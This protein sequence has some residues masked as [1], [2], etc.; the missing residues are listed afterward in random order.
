[1]Q[2]FI[3]LVFSATVILFGILECIDVVD[4]LFQVIDE[5]LV[6]RSHILRDIKANQVVQRVNSPS[7][8]QRGVGVCAA[9]DNVQL[10]ST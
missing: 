6:S 8:S 2:R 4:A 3:G 7:L 1:L 10:L 9:R 5:A